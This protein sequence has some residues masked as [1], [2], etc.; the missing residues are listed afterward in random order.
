MTTACDHVSGL[1]SAPHA[2]SGA[3]E[4][5]NSHS[6]GHFIE[7]KIPPEKTNVFYLTVYIFTICLLRLCDFFL[8]LFL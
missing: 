3:S 2:A 5:V 4:T 7:K 6:K 8:S 1:M